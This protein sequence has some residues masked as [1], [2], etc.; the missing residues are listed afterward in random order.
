MVLFG[1]DH[2]TLDIN[3][4][5]AKYQLLNDGITTYKASDIVKIM[6]K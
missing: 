5:I 3:V 4:Y 1:C 6:V 2:L